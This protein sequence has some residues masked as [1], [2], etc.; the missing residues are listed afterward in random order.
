MGWSGR[1]RVAK[2]LKLQERREV[3]PSRRSL[4]AC[5]PLGFLGAINGALCGSAGKW[6]R[7]MEWGRILAYITGTVDQELL[8]RNEY[9]VA[10]NRIL[11]S[12]L[13]G[14]LKL[15]DVERTKLGEIGHRLGREALG[16]VAATAL[17][18]TILA[19][20][21]RLIA[22]KFDGSQARRA[23]GRPRIDREVEQL[24]VRMA[25]ENRS[26]GY[27]RIVGALAN[28]GHEISDQTVGNVLRRHGLPPAPERK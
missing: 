2:K 17:P 27:D 8:L 22:R 24:I 21:R 4:A 13:K 5:R 14:R 6:G 16:E 18:D 9:L 11:K 19:W 10:E 12:Q 28:L 3:I 23:P 15:S 25:E 1:A 7:V 26:W 20:Y